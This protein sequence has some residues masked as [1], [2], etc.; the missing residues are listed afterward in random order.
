M[1][2]Y[3]YTLVTL[4][5]SIKS[6]FED[7]VF[8]IGGDFNRKDLSRFTTAFPDLKPVLAGATRRGLALDEV[9]TNQVDHIVRKEILRPLC[10]DN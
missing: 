9:Y 10:K 2:S 6:K 1:D 4:V 7:S 8:F 5:D 3:I